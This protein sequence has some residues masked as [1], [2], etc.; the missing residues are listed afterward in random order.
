MKYEL[1]FLFFFIE[2]IGQMVK[3]HNSIKSYGNKPKLLIV[4]G[5]INLSTFQYTPN[6]Y[7]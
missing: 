7:V 6:L 2:V 5:N 1:W 3:P 4:N